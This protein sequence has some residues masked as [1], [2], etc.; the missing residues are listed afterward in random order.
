MTTLV[1]DTLPDAAL[2]KLAALAMNQGITT[3]QLVAVLVDQYL[4]DE[5]D[6]ADA[7]E[8]LHDGETPIPWSRVKM[9]L[10]L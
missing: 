8:A 5:E 1:L 2:S 6:N 9:E 3:A 7:V 10:G 4:E